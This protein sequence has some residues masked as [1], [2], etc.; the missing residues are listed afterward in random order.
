MLKTGNLF[1]T[2][3]TPGKD[4]SF[5]DLLEGRDFRVKRIVSQG[6]C[7]PQGFWYQQLED[8]WVAVLS[9]SARLEFEGGA[10]QPLQ[11]GDYVLIPAGVRHRV[12]W[13]DPQSPTVWLAIHFLPKP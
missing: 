2:I 1:Q 9:G 10:V 11:R 12:Q 3:P 5:Q 13:T 8:E 4:E 6:H 7:S